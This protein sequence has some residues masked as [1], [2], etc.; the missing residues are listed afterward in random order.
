MDRPG[1]PADE[2]RHARRRGVAARPGEASGQISRAKLKVAYLR[3]AP[4]GAPTTMPRVLRRWLRTWSSSHGLGV[5]SLK[6]FLASHERGIALTLDAAQ[7]D[8]DTRNLLAPEVLLA[9][10]ELDQD[11]DLLRD[12]WPPDRDPRELFALADTFGR[13]YA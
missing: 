2:I 6:T 1:P 4:A 10:A 9:L 7:Y 3:V 13:P 8:L 12:C 5:G 11:P